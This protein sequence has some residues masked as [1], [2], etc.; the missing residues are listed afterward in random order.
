MTEEGR[1]LL[2]AELSKEREK[3]PLV[4]PVFTH[5]FLHIISIPVIQEKLASISAHLSE[6]LLPTNSPR[7]SWQTFPFVVI[8]SKQIK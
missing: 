5:L 6:T 3:D 7:T 8:T 2:G 4:I 1:D